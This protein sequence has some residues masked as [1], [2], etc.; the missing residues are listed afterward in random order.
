M[1]KLALSVI[2]DLRESEPSRS[3]EVNIAGD[4]FA[5]A[6][7]GLMEIA[8]SNLLGNAWK[9][10]LKTKDARIEFGK[11]RGEIGHIGPMRP[12]YFVKDNG[13]GFSPEYAEKMFLPFQRLHSAEE[14]EGTGIGLTIVERIIRRHGGKIWAESETGKGAVVFFTL[15]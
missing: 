3:V 11:V 9:F 1:S 13:V 8:L 12:I 4:V 14:F 2:S 6:D 15:G 5:F 10:T 7:P